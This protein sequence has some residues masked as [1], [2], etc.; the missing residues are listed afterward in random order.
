MARVYLRPTG[1]SAEFS[2]GFRAYFKYI[3]NGDYRVK[4]HSPI[5]YHARLERNPEL[6]EPGEPLSDL[7]LLFSRQYTHGFVPTI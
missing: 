4:F 7:S 5:R 1:L 6:T 3:K 2:W